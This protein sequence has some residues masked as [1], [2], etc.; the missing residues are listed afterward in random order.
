MSAIAWY[1]RL[2]LPAEERFIFISFPSI[3]WRSPDGG[4]GGILSI[5]LVVMILG[6]IGVLSYSLAYPK[7]GER[8]TLFSVLGPE[9][10]LE[11]YP[12]DLFVNEQISLI[13]V[14]QNYES[15]VVDYRIEVM[16]SGREVEEIAPITLEHEG[17]WQ[18][19]VNFAFTEA[20]ERQKVE[21]LLY[22]SGKNEPYDNT[23][24]YINIRENEL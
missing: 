2:R 5:L 15:Q 12:K 21:F 23:Y 22:K 18:R 7:V 17:E 9:G 4:R 24:L 10:R 16:V 20:G 11:G 1:R 3:S 19:E 8:Y 6:T 13:L 14:I